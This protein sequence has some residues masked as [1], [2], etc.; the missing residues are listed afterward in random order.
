MRI[1]RFTKTLFKVLLICSAIG[2]FGT[3]NAQDVIRASGGTNISIDTFYSGEY[4]SISGPTIRETAVAQLQAGGTIILTLPAQYE[5][6]TAL[7][8]EN[9]TITIAPVGAQTTEL[10]VEF[11]SI[12]ASEATFT[13]TAQ[14]RSAGAGQ[15]PG[16]VTIGGLEL[17]PATDVVPSTGMITNTGTT[18]PATANYGNLSLAQ[19]SATTLQVETT[20]S[21]SGTVVPEQSILAGNSI[22]VYSITR[23]QGGN[24]KQNIALNDAADWSL[25]NLTGG[26]SSTTLTPAGDRTSAT[27]SS[28]VTGTVQI[29]AF[30]DGLD[31]VPS[32][33][34]TVLPRSPNSMVINQQPSAT[35]TAGELFGT[36][37]V[38]HIKDQFGNLVTTDNETEVTAEIA[39]G[40][41]TLSGTLTQTASSGVVSFTDLSL[42]K[43]DTVVLRFTSS[44][45][46]V[47][48]SNDIVV[49]PNVETTLTYL[50]QP[51]NTARNSAIDPPV[52]VR[53]L[54]NFGNFV[55]KSGVNITIIAKD[56]QGTE[57]GTFFKGSATTTIATNIDGIAVFSNLDIRNNTDE[58]EYTLEASFDG[59]NAPV[60]SNPFIVLSADDFAKFSVTDINGDPIGEQE[61]GVPFNIRITALDGNDDA[62][63]TFENDFDG[64]IDLSADADIDGT[65]Q[66]SFTDQ[67]FTNGILETSIILT[68]SGETRIYAV[69]DGTDNENNPITR[70]GR[71]NIFNI[72][73][74][75]VDFTNSEMF[76]DPLQITANGT[77][78]SEITV[79]LKD[80]FGN[81]L[82]IGGET[83]TIT[84]DAGTLS[85]GSASGETSLTAVDQGDGT[86]TATLTSSINIETAILEAVESSTVIA[87][88]QVEFT[89]GDLHEFLITLPQDNESPAQQ[90]AGSPFLITVEALDQNNNRVEGYSATIEFSSNSTIRNG[91]SATITDGLLQDHSIELTKS[92]TNITISVQDPNIFGVTGASEVFT[93]VAAAPDV[94]SS[95]AG[96]SPLVIQNDGNSTSLVTVTLRDQFHNR[97]LTDE[98]GSLGISIEQ[99]E[100]DGEPSSGTPDASISGLSFNSSVS[101]YTATLTSTTT[102]ED[103]K[104]TVEINNIEIPQKPVIQIVMPNTWEPSGAPQQRNDWNRAENWSLG[105]VPTPDDFV[106][107]PGGAADY[108]DLDQNLAVEEN[109]QL[110]GPGIGSLEIQ[111]NGELVLFGGNVIWVG[112]NVLV[113]G[114]LDIE[115][116]TGLTIDGNFNGSGTFASGAN[117]EIKLKGN[118]NIENFLA[119]TTGTIVKFEGNTQQVITT[120]NLL[121]QR[122]EILNDVLVTSG[123]LID[124]A[125]IFVSEGNTIEFQEG[126]G[127][128]IDNLENIFGNGSLI[129]N[130]NTLVVRGDLSLLNVDTSEGTV[131]FG[132]NIGE[133]PADYPEL[134]QQQVSNFLQMKN[135]IVNNVQGV[136]TFDD[137]I[138]TD[139]GSLTLENGELIIGSGKNFIADNVI[140][141]NGFLTFRRTISQPGWKMITTPVASNY[142]NFFDGLTLQGITDASFTDRQPNLLYY[143]E[144]FEG[145]DNQR[146]RSP[147]SAINNFV[148]GRGYFFFVF[149]N[150]DGDTDYNDTLP[151][152]LTASGQENQPTAGNIF[153]FP[154]TY[155][156]EADTGWNLVGNPYGAT[157]DWDES[158]WVRTNVDN[159]IYIWDESEN[160]YRYW[161]GS[162]GSHGSGKIAPF[163]SFWIKANNADPTL[164]FEVSAKTTGGVFRKDPDRYQHIPVIALQLESDFYETSTHFSFTQNGSF[165][166]DSK[167]AYRL[168]PFDTHTYL[169]VFSLFKDGTELAINNLPRDF[170]KEI[171]IPVHAGA[172]KDGAFYSGQITMTWPEFENIPDSWS[173]KLKDT[174]T[175]NVIDL[176]KNEFYDFNVGSNAKVKQAPV[177]NTQDNFRLVKKSK[178]KAQ[179]A[180]F[181]LIIDPGVD[182]SELPKEVS[183]SQNYPNPFN[184]A[185][186]IEFGLPTE[187]RVR[188]DVYDMLGRRVQTIAN[189]R[190]QAGFHEVRFNG[191]S[192]ASGVY[193]YRLV[194]SEKVLSR[195]MTLIK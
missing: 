72:V 145:T 138:I 101:T 77:S 188:I 159:V 139:G 114:T 128:T 131:I 60:A 117:T 15:G 149:G 30:F 63:N 35:A 25:L 43:A 125:E 169:E 186:T 90:T 176:R 82:I 37:P 1:H 179:N 170:G 126:A 6:N 24:F 18:S 16:R 167:D 147:G 26:I 62:Y 118:L 87:T 92:G 66:I 46:D 166:V 105:N 36:Q 50:Q 127:I 8:G 110:V 141:N 61:A 31:L 123:D 78:T 94:A 122:M 108:P 23:D 106:I 150:V 5:W 67:D 195:K 75:G 162:A 14:S 10:E 32:G 182:G 194:T 68:S 143:D 45:L 86:Y 124:T 84:T 104:I 137:I 151:R 158:T 88:S 187:D 146:W 120:P 27:F 184:P 56:D 47:V 109:G 73:P 160:Q 132:I 89:A 192:L 148:P 34:I 21:G 81:N 157:I 144:T 113:H 49:A 79:Q 7:T 55:K 134:S 121:V 174:K 95:L 40:K 20:A 59:I 42:D 17:R 85:N 100:L 116:N 80:Q 178:E 2:G 71:S 163:Q 185:T 97:V 54:D 130:D 64:T 51:T 171:E 193:F 102:I 19:G 119:R 155:T 22:T 96:A 115:D 93:I 152:T 52:E 140:Y 183:L 168:L 161:N 181:R 173:I 189:E 133:D 190:F 177:L 57:A 98:S 129:L 13:V 41:G 112:G 180:R 142:A 44:G 12:N 9:I 154:V 175:G 53:L 4:T 165:K 11:T 135:A 103:V 28:Q 191:N 172:V 99:T 3:A 107:I 83:I 69:F 76:G 136:R 164:S 156:A 74:T 65:S 39:T 38:I 153:E 91:G 48:S 58:G 111:E 29:E 33:T 70:D